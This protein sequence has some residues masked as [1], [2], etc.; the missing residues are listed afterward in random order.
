[1]SAFFSQIQNGISTASAEETEAI[2]AELSTHLPE[3]QV[4]AL[5]GDL[6]AGKSTFVRGLAKAWG[7]NRPITSPT[8]NLM[9][10]YQGSRQLIHVDAYRLEDPT[11]ADALLIEDLLRAPWCLAIEWPEKMPS[12]W[13]KNAWHVALAIDHHHHSIQLNLPS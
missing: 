6:G 3:D 5:H 9:N 11:E 12:Y 7:I 10:V 8:Y 1:M 13:M 2:A 4:L